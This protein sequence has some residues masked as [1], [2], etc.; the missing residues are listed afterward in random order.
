MAELDR[1]DRLERDLALALAEIDRLRTIEAIRE[2]VY[3]VCRGIDRIDGE[4][5]RSAFHP[6]ATVRF[7][8]LYDGGLEGWID[9]VVTFQRRQFQAHHLVGNINI[10]VDGD[11]AFAE[12]YELARH[13]TPIDGELRDQV[14]AMR[15]LDR[16]SRRDGEW[17]I[18]ERTKVV[19]WGRIISAGEAAYDNSPLEKGR[20]D[21]SDA[22]YRLFS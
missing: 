11:R 17:R 12:S 19:D 18:D 6:D 21:Q 9:S 20:R 8:K 10:K 16:L 22:S 4:L 7:G 14:L 13:K 1:V 2:C 5:L 15:T 3:R